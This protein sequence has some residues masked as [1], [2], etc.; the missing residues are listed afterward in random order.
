MKQRLVKTF[1]IFILLTLLKSVWTQNAHSQDLNNEMS[2]NYESEVGS[3]YHKVAG[4]RRPWMGPVTVE[5][6]I[7]KL[8]EECEKQAALRCKN[9]AVRVTDFDVETKSGNAASVL[10]TV[11]AQFECG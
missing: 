10:I 1:S 2:Q 8:K 9:G 3:F 7:E 5:N 11:A 4:V 6:I